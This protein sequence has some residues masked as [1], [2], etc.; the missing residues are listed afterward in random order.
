[1]FHS[2]TL[3]FCTWPFSVLFVLIR[4]CSASFGAAHYASLFHSCV[5]HSAFLGIIRPCSASF[6]A[7]HIASP[8]RS[9]TGSSRRAK[10]HDPAVQ[11]LVSPATHGHRHP[12]GGEESTQGG[13]GRGQGTGAGAAQLHVAQ[14]PWRPDEVRPGVGRGRSQV[15]CKLSHC[16]RRFFQKV[17][18][19]FLQRLDDGPWVDSRVEV[20]K[21]EYSNAFNVPLGP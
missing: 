7:A 17:P 18:P 2:F 11:H 15:R 4:P 1:M 8:L 5:L 21:M 10:R 14:S 9:T 20:L 6:G 19:L 12:E 3:A 16:N 13:A